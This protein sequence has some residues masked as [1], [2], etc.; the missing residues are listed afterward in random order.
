MSCLGSCHRRARRRLCCTALPV[1]ANLELCIVSAPLWGWSL[2][3]LGLCCRAGNHTAMFPWM[4]R[5][6][7]PNPIIWPGL[8][9]YGVTELL[10][11]L[12]LLATQRSARMIYVTGFLLESFQR[13]QWE[14]C[15]LLSSVSLKIIW[16]T[17][18]FLALSMNSSTP[19]SGLGL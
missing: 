4:E 8:G 7:R 12:R 1:C 15:G 3:N 18:P 14:W 19:I 17:D 2:H 10:P 5:R 9:R 11:R 6:I 13:K 16:K